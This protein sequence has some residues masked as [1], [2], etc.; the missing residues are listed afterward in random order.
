MGERKGTCCLLLLEG[1]SGREAV[2]LQNKK[3]PNFMDIIRL[4]VSQNQRV[5]RVE[6]VTDNPHQL[7]RQIIDSLRKHFPY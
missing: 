7:A 6:T 4:R 2:P 1:R 5:K 3:K